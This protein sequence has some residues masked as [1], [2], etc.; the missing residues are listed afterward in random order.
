LVKDPGIDE[1]IFIIEFCSSQVLL[2]QLIVGICGLGV[3]VRYFI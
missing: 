2:K 1:L 3:L